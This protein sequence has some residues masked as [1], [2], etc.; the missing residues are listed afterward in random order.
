LGINLQSELEPLLAKLWDE[1]S[2]AHAYRFENYPG[3]PMTSEEAAQVPA[4]MKRDFDDNIAP[5][6]SG[7]T[8]RLRSYYSLD[9]FNLEGIADQFSRPGDRWEVRQVANINLFG[10]IVGAAAGVQKVAALVHTE[11][12][13]NRLPSDPPNPSQWQ[14]TAAMAFRERFLDPFQRGAAVQVGCIREIAIA[15]D[16][17]TKAVELIKE[18]VVWIC[19]SAIWQLSK[20]SDTPVAEFPGPLPGRAAKGDGKEVAGVIAVLADTV[21]LFAAVFAPELDIAD[22]ALTSIGVTGGSIAAMGSPSQTQNWDHIADAFPL[23]EAPP[24]VQE[25]IYATRLALGVLDENIVDLD[26][27]LRA[28]FDEDLAPGCLFSNS[29]V[30]TYTQSRG[31][32]SGPGGWNGFPDVTASTFGTLTFG[33]NNS[34]FDGVIAN[35]V[36]LYYAGHVN[37]PLVAEQYRFGVKLC[38][39]L[40]ITGVDLQFQRSVP[41]L[42]EAVETLGSVLRSTHDQCVKYAEAL[43]A[44]ANAYEYADAYEGDRIREL[45]GEIPQRLDLNLPPDYT[46]TLPGPR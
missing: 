8:G 40:R 5:D 20:T 4:E 1:A 17:L 28:G 2:A 45:E 46:G 38:D 22:L 44:A 39:G 21:S 7:L 25:V 3:P 41:K 36:Y 42:N 11:Q 19:K 15:V 27:K 12:W 9:D 43:V 16:T 30:G 29:Y 24:L 32:H 6:L 35:V 33:A 13:R 18:T 26:D 37:L 34:P 14:G 31:E 10:H 23:G